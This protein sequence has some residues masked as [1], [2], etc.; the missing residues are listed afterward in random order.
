MPISVPW[1]CYPVKELILTFRGAP[2][3]ASYWKEEERKK[4]LPH[5]KRLFALQIITNPGWG[6][7]YGRARFDI[8]KF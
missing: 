3:Q 5:L 6:K 2:G 8:Y 1:G 4:L 7:Q